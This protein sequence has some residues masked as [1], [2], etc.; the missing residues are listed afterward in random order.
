MVFRYFQWVMKKDRKKIS[1]NKSATG[2]HM[3]V[4]TAWVD[5]A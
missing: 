2:E 4:G 5:P 3:A 1:R